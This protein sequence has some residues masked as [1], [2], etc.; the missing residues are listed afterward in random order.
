MAIKKT[1]IRAVPASEDGNVV[2][3]D[4]TMK[5]E[6]G[7]EGEDDYYSNEKV[8]TVHATETNSLLETASLTGFVIIESY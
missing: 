2:R 7:T 5:Y 4:L 1:L 8:A 6:Q 3:R